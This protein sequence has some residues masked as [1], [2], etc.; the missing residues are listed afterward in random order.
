VT[1]AGWRDGDALRA[2]AADDAR[3]RANEEASLK[4][5]SPELAER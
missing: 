5:R 2:L 3:G 4:L 1:G